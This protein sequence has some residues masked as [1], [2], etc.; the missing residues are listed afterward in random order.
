[1]INSWWYSGSTSTIPLWVYY[2]KTPDNPVPFSETRCGPGIDTLHVTVSPAF[3][4]ADWYGA[5]S[6]GTLTVVGVNDFYYT[7]SE[8]HDDLLC[9]DKRFCFRV[10]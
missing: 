1:M 4:K 7:F 3:F 5:A 6:G 8:C 9:P 10:H 2:S